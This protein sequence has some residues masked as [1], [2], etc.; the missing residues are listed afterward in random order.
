MTSD[1]PVLKDAMNEA[2]RD[3][4]ANAQDTYYLI[5]TI[6]GP[7]PYPMMV[8]NFQ[9]VIGE[10]AKRQMLE[11]ERRLPDVAVA[12]IGGGS[13][14]MGLVP[15]VPGRPGVLHGGPT[16]LLPDDEARFWHRT[17]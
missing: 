5:D 6:A 8:P 3:W 2:S 11:A 16:Y 12:C 14:A 4:V 17:A 10:E 15:S 13:N 1:A 7:H 9:S